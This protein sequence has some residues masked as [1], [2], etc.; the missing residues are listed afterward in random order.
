MCI[1]G[2][3]IN[4]DNS[5]FFGSRPPEAMT[6]DGLRELV[7]HYAGPLTKEVMFCPCAMRASYAARTWEPIWEGIEF[8]EDGTARYGEIELTGHAANWVRNA[9]ALHE[10]GLNPYAFW[11]D[12]ARTKG[13]SPWLSMRMNDIHSVDQPGN[14][15]HSDFWRANPNCRR[16]P[17]RFARWQDA[18]LD[19]GCA[20]V[21]ER[22][23]AQV[24]ELL[25]A[26]DLDGLELDW[27]RFGYHFRPG[28]EAAGRELLTAFVCEVRRQAQLAAERLGHPVRLG[29]RV[30]AN[31]EWA[32]ELG[33][34][35]VAWA[36]ASLVDMVVPTA[37]WATTDYAMPIRLWRRLLPERVTLAAGLELLTRA[38]PA[39]PPVRSTAAMVFGYAANYLWQGA[40]R[41]YLFNHMDSETAVE[42]EEDRQR[43]QTMAGD[44]GEVC[45]QGRRHVVTY[46][47]TVPD[48]RE[49]GYA[50]PVDLNPQQFR[51]LRIPVGPAPTSGNAQLVLGLARGEA[52]A[53][54][55]EVRV[56]GELCPPASAPK[57]TVAENVKRL[58]AFDVPIPVI[59]E[60]ESVVEIRNA[61]YE[62]VQVVWAELLIVPEGAE[63]G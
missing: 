25:E 48:G 20:A 15:M 24:S 49:T 27:M 56:N 17:Y 62:P 44:A 45:R 54:Q 5:H 35:A 52:A 46:T 19:Y 58:A 50:L 29:V 1:A 6:E 31:P 7:D 14:F 55:Q 28:Q 26:F 43:I 37:F 63:L 39:A 8:G 60:G 47:D 38:Y 9:L 13:V 4:E 41:I 53:F 57:L 16:V 61:A 21:R 30:P 34:D 22:A 51:E 18:A 11:L 59:G 12:Y 2:I 40:D 33:M 23:L 32:A 3:A 42:K 36:Q 10:K